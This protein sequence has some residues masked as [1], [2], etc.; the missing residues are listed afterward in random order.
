M[1]AKS[2]KIDSGIKCPECPKCNELMNGAIGER[3]P[4][5]GDFSI[6]S[7]CA[8]PLRYAADMTLRRVTK[9]EFSKLPDSFVRDMKRAQKAILVFIAERKERD[10]FE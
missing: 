9:K 5:P 7:Y 2:F 3:M 8:V 6:C 10:D 1:T 4:R